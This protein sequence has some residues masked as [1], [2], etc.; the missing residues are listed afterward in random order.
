LLGKSV[1]SYMHDAHVLCGG[2][3]LNL[4]LLHAVKAMSLNLKYEMF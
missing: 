4:N 2:E 1:A 3:D